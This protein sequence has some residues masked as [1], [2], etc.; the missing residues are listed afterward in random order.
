M[1]EKYVNPG[2]VGLFSI[3]GKGIQFSLF[4]KHT[5]EKD[6]HESLSLFSSTLVIIFLKM[7]K[8]STLIRQD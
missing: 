8:T 6:I 7:L 2:G 3:R 4:T 5:R 1:L